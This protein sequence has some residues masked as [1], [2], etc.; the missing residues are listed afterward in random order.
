MGWRFCGC[1]TVKPA[2]GPLGCPPGPAGKRKKNCSKSSGEPGE[3]DVTALRK[4]TEFAE[5]AHVPAS[6][7]AVPSS[8][9]AAVMLLICLWR[10]DV[11]VCRFEICAWSA[12]IWPFTAGRP[13]GCASAGAAKKI[14][15]SATRRTEVMNPPHYFM[16]HEVSRGP[17][18]DAIRR[19]THR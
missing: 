1:T 8:A 19:V 17:K 13:P 2:A 11:A 16:D 10:L 12:S 7:C 6:A 3:A 14:S 9:M 18:E 15:D 4:C 5:P